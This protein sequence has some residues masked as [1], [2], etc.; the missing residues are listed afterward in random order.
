[1]TSITNL[2]LTQILLFGMENPRHIQDNLL[3][4]NF[5]KRIN[6]AFF[7]RWDSNYTK[8]VYLGT[9]LIVNFQDGVQTKHGPAIRLVI[10]CSEAKK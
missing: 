5:F 8:F 1:M 2:T 7:A 10:N 9:G 4:K 3:L 6:T